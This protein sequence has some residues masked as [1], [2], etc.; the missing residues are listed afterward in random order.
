MPP[1]LHKTW[2]TVL[3]LMLIWFDWVS[4]FLRSSAYYSVEYHRQASQWWELWTQFQCQSTSQ[5]ITHYK[6]RLSIFILLYF[7]WII[8]VLLMEIIISIRIRYSEFMSW[9][10]GICD[11]YWAWWCIVC[12]KW[13]YFFLLFYFINFCKEDWN[14]IWRARHIKSIICNCGNTLAF[15]EIDTID[16]SLH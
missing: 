5:I 12:S 15:I 13:D 14:E 16:S 1:H 2:T 9:E 7:C 3:Q 4:V 11:R 10:D 8:V 6:F